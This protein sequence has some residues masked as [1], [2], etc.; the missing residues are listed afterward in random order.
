MGGPRNSVPTVAK[1]LASMF[2]IVHLT[3]PALQGVWRCA[4]TRITKIRIYEAADPLYAA[5]FQFR[6]QFSGI[7]AV[8]LP[9]LRE[10][11]ERKVCTSYLLNKD[12]KAG[13]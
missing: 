5:L 7:A 4:L 10:G 13:C 8:I 11:W 9:D 2:A 6:L 1:S 3:G 12:F